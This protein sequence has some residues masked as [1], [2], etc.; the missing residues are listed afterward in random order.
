[1]IFNNS[2]LYDILKW[3]AGVAFPALGV[4]YFAIAS[5][6]GLPYTEQVVG[7]IAA[8]T[9]LCDTLLGISSIKYKKMIDGAKEG[10]I[11]VL[12]VIDKE[13][14]EDGN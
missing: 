7:T 9:T 13:E 10:K 5:I 1:M 3:V 12:N 6:W 14:N 11:T 8:I 4:F 2:K